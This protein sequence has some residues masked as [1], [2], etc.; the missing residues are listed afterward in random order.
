MFM[1]LAGDG[2]SFFLEFRLICELLRINC[3]L[4]GIDHFS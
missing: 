3:E 4:S 2:E 1:G